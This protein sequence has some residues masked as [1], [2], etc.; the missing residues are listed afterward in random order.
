M[1]K[2]LLVLCDDAHLFCSV[3]QRNIHNMC[4]I[5]I[6]LK[7]EDTPSDK[8]ARRRMPFNLAYDA[9][10]AASELNHEI[11]KELRRLFDLAMEIQRRRRSLAQSD[12]E[13]RDSYEIK[14]YLQEEA[15]Q[16]MNALLTTFK[17]HPAIV[18]F[19]DGSYV[20]DYVDDFRL[21]GEYPE[22]HSYFIHTILSM[23]TANCLDRIRQCAYCHLWIATRR[24]D[25]RFCSTLCRQRWFE[26]RTDVRKRRNEARNKCY[27][28]MVGWAKRSIEIVR[29]DSRNKGAKS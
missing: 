17:Q 7:H 8:R 12:A 28:N 19:H 9:P 23:L 21:P 27:R 18:H 5:K 11:P 16:E 20:K 22:S 14:G 15:L 1:P 3:V 25:Q 24:Q 2:N 6:I 26:T 10:F 4:S 29:K 13:E